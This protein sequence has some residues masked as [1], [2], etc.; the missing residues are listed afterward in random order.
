MGR[1]VAE[2]KK[3]RYVSKI[4]SALCP[5]AV[6]RNC[7]IIKT[8]LK[9]YAPK[10]GIDI[11]KW[12][13]NKSVVFHNVLFCRIILWLSLYCALSVVP[14][15]LSLVPF[16]TT[17]F[18]NVLICKLLCLPMVPNMSSFCLFG[19]FLLCNL[20]L[21]SLWCFAELMICQLGDALLR[22]PW[23]ALKNVLNPESIMQVWFFGT[24]LHNRIAII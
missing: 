6:E 13:D 3:S 22:K 23:C 2:L 8:L 21:F 1:H 17:C 5:F 15:V 14:D 24:L 20:L 11:L 19:T 4:I 16:G 12:I 7:F 10:R 18:S 9:S